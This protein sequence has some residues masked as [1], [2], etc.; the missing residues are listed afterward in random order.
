MKNLLLIIGLTFATFVASGQNYLSQS[1]LNQKSLLVSNTLSISNLANFSGQS[2]IFGVRWT[3]SALTGVSVTG[4]GNTTTLIKD[5]DLWSRAD[6]DWWGARFAGQGSSDTNTAISPHNLF[7]RLL[8]GGSGANAAVTFTFIPIYD[9]LETPVVGTGMNWSFA[10]TSAGTASV[11]VATNVP[12]WKWPGAKK[13][14]LLSIVNADT[15]ASS[16]VWVDRV[17]LNGY[18][19]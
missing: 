18:R 6:G 11:T 14:R 4:A 9:G 15:D 3:N 19:P 10:V 13:L 5:V 8:T 16:E 12:T 1:F 2:N 7:V 17:S